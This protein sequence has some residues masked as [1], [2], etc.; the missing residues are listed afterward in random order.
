MGKSFLLLIGALETKGGAA[1]A[2]GRCRLGEERVVATSE[3]W[4]WPPWVQCAGE[5]LGTESRVKAGREAEQG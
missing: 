3:E 2:Q 1:G 5:E 4:R